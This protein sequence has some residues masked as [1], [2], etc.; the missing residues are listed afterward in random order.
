M[1]SA[2]GPHCPYMDIDLNGRGGYGTILLENPQ[3]HI[4]VS[5]NNAK[6]LALKLLSQ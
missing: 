6:S 1:S 5:S 3:G 2:G 4:I